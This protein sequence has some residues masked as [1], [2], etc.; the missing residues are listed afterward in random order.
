[1][2]I[3]IISEEDF[4]ALLKKDLIEIDALPK[5]VVDRLAEKG[6]K[7]A[8][9]ESCTGGLI[10]KLVTDCSGASAV[11][12][13][14]VCSYAN[15]IKEKVLG[16][17]HDTLEACGAVSPQTAKEMAEGI[18]R[19]SGADVGVA[20]TGIAGPGGGTPE[21][22]VGTIYIACATS[23][24]TDIVLADFADKNNPRCKNRQLAA[25]LALYCVFLGI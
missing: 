14:G 15:E 8:T 2:E 18:K 7:I 16:V 20:V 3:R 17:K 4:L 19:L 6:L 25:A 5:L 22:P 24:K 21:K 11:F 9:A 13:C 23:V 10:S 12:D 1:M